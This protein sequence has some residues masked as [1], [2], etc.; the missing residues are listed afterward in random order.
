MTVICNGM[1]QPGG[2]GG[3]WNKQALKD[4]RVF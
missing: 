3:Q 2:Q 4:K 1:E